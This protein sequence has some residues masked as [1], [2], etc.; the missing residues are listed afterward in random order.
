M[1]SAIKPIKPDFSPVLSGDVY[2]IISWLAILLIAGLSAFFIARYSA[3]RFKTDEK[4]TAVCFM[5]LAVISSLIML[6]FFGFS[7]ITLKGIVI[8]LIFILSSF[9]DVKTRECDDF[10]HV[11]IVIAAFIGT[12]MTALPGMIISAV[13]VFA[14]M[15]GTILITGVE[16]GGA[17]I[18]MA[19]ACAFLLGVRRGL[20]GLI[21]GLI[22]AVIFNIFKNRKNKKAGFPMIPYLA[23]GFMTAFFM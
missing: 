9:E 22:L 5:A 15:V 19:A 20:L 21:F 18:K 10:L 4:K 8:S 1:I 2:S 3:K 7:A 6:C 17:D 12:G 13:F 23:V 14:V 11:M 16:I